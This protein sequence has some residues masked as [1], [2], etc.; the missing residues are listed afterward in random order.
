MKSRLLI[1]I[2]VCITT[3]LT[4]WMFFNFKKRWKEA[5][6]FH[7]II[8]EAPLIVRHLFIAPEQLGVE[9]WN[10][11]DSAVYQL[12]TNTARK[13]ITFHVAAQAA[14][15][16]KQHWLRTAELIHLNK[17]DIE[18]WKVLSV[19]SLRPGSEKAAVLFTRGAIPFPIPQQPIQLYPVFLEHIGEEIIETSTGT[20][21]CEHY[22]AQLQSPDGTYE[23]ILELW[24]NSS[25]SPLGIVHARWRDE[26]LELV[27]VQ[28]SLPFAIPEMLSKTI[29][30]FDGRNPEGNASPLVSP[31][32]Q[33]HDSGIGGEDLKL[34]SLTSLSGVSLKLMPVL[35]HYDTADLDHPYTRLL[36][37]LIS[38]GGKRLASRQVRF[39]WSK[40]S[41]WVKMNLSGRLV[42]S[43][44]EITRQSNFRVATREGRLVLSISGEN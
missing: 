17:V 28:T 16:S 13:Q 44:D 11:G 3:L 19:K 20:F 24:S 15:P 8:S 35:Y 10:V 1:L 9:T 42:L 22:F 34:E 41:F 23:P 6:V 31:C 7:S 32:S 39:T 21:K 40:G 43:L 38:H 25:V 30:R 36:F 12:K 37:Q 29:K 18:I 2:L 5:A 33:C 4:F 26:V 27:Q 14:Q